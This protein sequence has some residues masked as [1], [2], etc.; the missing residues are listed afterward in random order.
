MS[1]WSENFLQLFDSN[2]PRDTPFW[3]QLLDQ[4]IQQLHEDEEDKGPETTYCASYTAS[5]WDAMIA[6]MDMTISDDWYEQEEDGE[7]WKIALRKIGWE[8]QTESDD[9]SMSIGL[10]IYDL[11][12][13]IILILDVM[14]PTDGVDFSRYDIDFQKPE[15]LWDLAET[16]IWETRCSDPSEEQKKLLTGVYRIMLRL[17]QPIREYHKCETFSDRALITSG[18]ET[19]WYSK[20]LFKSCS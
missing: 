2:Q 5:V 18:R 11:H 16:P 12:Q 20:L 3:V 8:L 15:N 4:K 7:L 6:I 19:H 17:I 14:C 13:K 10:R 1:T 9:F